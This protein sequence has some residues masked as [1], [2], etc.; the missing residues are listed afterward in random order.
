MFARSGQN[1][2]GKKVD[3]NHPYLC[4]SFISVWRYITSAPFLFLFQAKASE[5][6]EGEGKDGVDGSLSRPGSGGP[7]APAESEQSAGVARESTQTSVARS[8]I[9]KSNTR[10]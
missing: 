10:I 3:M 2:T 5:D 9:G 6:E 1:N 8:I 7:D 4:T